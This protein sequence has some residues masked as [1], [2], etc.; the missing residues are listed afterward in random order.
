MTPKAVRRDSL[1]RRDFLRSMIT[2]VGLAALGGC[3]PAVE[4]VPTPTPS[5]TVT[6]T[7]PSA[8]SGP[9]VLNFMAPIVQDVELRDVLEWIIDRWHERN[10]LVRVEAYWTE[11]QS[12][13]K[14]LFSLLDG[15]DTSVDLTVMGF[16]NIPTFTSDGYAAPLDIPDIEEFAQEQVKILTQEGQVYAV[17]WLVD[18]IGYL[19]NKQLFRGAGLDPDSP[20]RTLNELIGQSVTLTRNDIYGLTYTGLKDWGT[21]TA[22]WLC[23]LYALGGYPMSENTDAGLPTLHT[24]QAVKALE[25]WLDWRDRYMMVPPDVAAR[26]STE[27]LTSFG[28]RR[29]GGWT[30]WHAYVPRLATEMRPE[31]IG[32]DLPPYFNPYAEG[33]GSW[34]GGW[35]AMV[36]SSSNKQVPAQEFVR[37]LTGDLAQKH[38]AIT[39]GRCSR[40]STFNDPEVMEKWPHL[41]KVQEIIPY[42]LIR[43]TSKHWPEMNDAIM[44]AIGT[45]LNEGVTPDQALE[46]AQERVE[47]IWTVE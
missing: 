45:A 2:T 23:L 13:P 26:S 20:P 28:K 21:P 12:I 10:P 11:G 3:C 27:N 46:T 41:Q 37:F 22:E 24:P 6:P 44:D 33:T 35:A 42:A 15:G 16:E 8:P 34:S 14:K 38:L 9:T 18:V 19:Y 36:I 39:I 40:N 1:T 4:A 25:T 43:P 30:T 31:D 17:P 7:S 47:A 29:I 5:P 32:F